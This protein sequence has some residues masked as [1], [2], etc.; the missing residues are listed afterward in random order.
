[1]KFRTKPI[2]DVEAVLYNGDNGL[3]IVKFTEQAAVYYPRNRLLFIDTLEGRMK[4]EPG[5]WIIKGVS[6]EFYPC[7]PDV[8][9][10]KYEAQ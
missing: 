7:R 9:F 8:F 5:D 4:A 10:K 2:A 3:E 1:M 6:G